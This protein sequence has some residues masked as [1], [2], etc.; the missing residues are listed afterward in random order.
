MMPWG[1][2][3]RKKSLIKLVENDAIATDN[4]HLMKYRCILCKENLCTKD[5]KMNKF[6]LIVTKSV[7][8]IT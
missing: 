6:V 5:L 8:F 4:S 1:W 7:N 3:V 2:L